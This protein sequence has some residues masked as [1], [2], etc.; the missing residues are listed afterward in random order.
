MTTLW[1]DTRYA[2]RQF[3]KSPGFTAVVV[4]VLALGIGANTALFSVINGVLLKSLPV[5]DPQDLRVIGWRRGENVQI[6]GLTSDSHAQRGF[7]KSFCMAFP[8]PLYRQF[9]EKAEGFSHVFGFSYPED[10]VTVSG[11]G[12]AV[13]THG[14]TVSGN[15]FAGYGARVL[16]GRPITPEDDR[17]G[18]D[19]VAV[20]TYPA[21]PRADA[22]GQQHDLYDRGRAARAVPR[23]PERRSQRVL[24]APHRAAADYVG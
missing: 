22:Y 23:T 17:V 16:I 21:C 10:G 4:L 13:A 9:V 3:W 2:F 11:T 14:L 18:A 1:Q 5:R 24:C 19:P 6:D 12:F 20:I 15:F 8:Y 7:G